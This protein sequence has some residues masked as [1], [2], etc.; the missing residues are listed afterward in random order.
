MS[1]SDFALPGR[2]AKKRTRPTFVARSRSRPRAFVPDFSRLPLAYTAAPATGFVRPAFVYLTTVTVRIVPRRAVRGA[3]MPSGVIDLFLQA[4]LAWSK[5]Q[6]STNSRTSPPGFR[7]A[8]HSPADDSLW[9]TQSEKNDEP[10]WRSPL[11]SLTK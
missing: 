5:T 6:R 3:R 8:P 2:V 1:T 4:F 7:F 9:L 11:I 10:L